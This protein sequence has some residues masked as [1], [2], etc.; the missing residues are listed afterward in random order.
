MPC[1]GRG[2]DKLVGVTETAL[3]KWNAREEIA[4]SMIPMIGK[5]HRDK[6]VTVLLHSRSLVNK[7]VISILKTHRSPARSAARSSRSPRRSPSCRPSPRS[8]SA[9]RRST[10]AF[11]PRRLPG[12]RP[13]S[14][15][16]GVHRRGASP[17]PLAPTSRAPRGPRDVVLYG[18]G[19]IGR[20]LARLLIEKAG[21][22]NG[23][24]LRAIVV[25]KGARERPRQARA[26][27]C[28]AT[29]CTAV[30][31]HR[32]RSTRTNNTIIANGTAIQVIYSDDPRDGRLHRVRHQRRHRGRQHRP[33]ARRGGPVAAP[34]ARASPACC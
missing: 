31:G 12:R 2:D 8:T 1:N 5:L 16:R 33:L 14:V 4:E 34:A 25:R 32:S 6:G 3:S 26:R 15:G 7:S 18:F 13:R 17:A 23:L 21:G 20:L 9:P 19:R 30:R 22:G 29:R 28:A 11:S 24:R 10:S 27:C